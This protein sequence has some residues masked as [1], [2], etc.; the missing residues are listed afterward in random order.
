MRDRNGDVALVPIAWVE[1]PTEAEA[2]QL[3][4]LMDT[5]G[6]GNMTELS[7]ERGRYR[8]VRHTGDAYAPGETGRL[9]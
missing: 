3:K 2:H 5:G 7:R 1:R 9:S 4:A 8:S 6:T